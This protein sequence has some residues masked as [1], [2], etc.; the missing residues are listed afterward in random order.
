[1]NTSNAKACV[2]WHPFSQFR[3][4]AGEVGWASVASDQER[5]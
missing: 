2:G 5:T 1:M 4:E 3:R